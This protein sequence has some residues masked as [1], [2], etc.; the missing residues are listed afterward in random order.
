MVSTLLERVRAWAE[1]EG[2]ALQVPLGHRMEAGDMVTPLGTYPGLGQWFSL[3]S[4]FSE[5][6][7][8][9]EGIK[10]GQERERERIENRGSKNIPRGSLASLPPAS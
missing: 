9:K 8:G 3:S 6:D 4:W 10:S 2:R 1:Q 5:Q 7:H